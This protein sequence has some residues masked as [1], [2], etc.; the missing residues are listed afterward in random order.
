MQAYNTR[1]GFTLVELLVVIGIIAVLIA[2]LLP[3]LNRAREAARSVSCMSNHRQL[4]FALMMYA[5]EHDGR[6]PK[7]NVNYSSFTWEGNTETN[8]WIQWFSAPFVGR[9]FGN[10]VW[11][12]GS[13][14][15]VIYCPS[16]SV[17]EMMA[18]PW[19]IAD[20]NRNGIGLNHMWNVGLW[21]DKVGTTRF[22]GIRSPSRFVLLSDTAYQGKSPHQGFRE[23]GSITRL[24]NGLPVNASGS[25]RLDDYGTNAYRHRGMCILGFAD[26]HVAAYD[27][28]VAAH[29]SGE[30][31]TVA[32]N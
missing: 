16:L 19:W 18:M 2:I 21:P 7:P 5:D 6:L 32:R 27:D 10:T 28:V 3:A 4:L 24:V 26:G 29:Q 15:T 30:I 9:Y 17:P 31:T 1:S 20:K 23:W 22:R 14:N 13:S 25:V 8:A 11:P 12:N